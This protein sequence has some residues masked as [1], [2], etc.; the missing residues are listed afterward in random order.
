[1]QSIFQ[2]TL[3]QHVMVFTFQ[4]FTNCIFWSLFIFSLSLLAF[5][6]CSARTTSSNLVISPPLES[7]WWFRSHGPKC[8]DERKTHSTT[9]YSRLDHQTQSHAQK[10]V[11][12]EVSQEAVVDIRLQETSHLLVRIRDVGLLSNSQLNQGYQP[13]WFN[14]GLVSV[15][16]GGRNSTPRRNNNT[17]LMLLEYEAKTSSH[18]TKMANLHKTHQSRTKLTT[19]KAMESHN[20]KDNLSKYRPW[21]VWSPLILFGVHSLTPLCFVRIQAFRAIMLYVRNSLF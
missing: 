2:T 6:K 16:L 9:G 4:S 13:E 14:W 8:P 1:M 19:V 15:F 21:A 12:F 7:L 10:Y 11:W 18:S 3:H 5:H 17:T 20:S